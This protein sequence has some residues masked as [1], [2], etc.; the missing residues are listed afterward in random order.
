M[1]AEFPEGGFQRQLFQ[2][3]ANSRL[4][5][6]KYGPSLTSRGEEGYSTF[7]FWHERAPADIEDLLRQDQKRVLRWQGREAVPACPPSD[8][9]ALALQMK[10][11]AG[12]PHAK[13][14][15]PQVA[16]AQRSQKA[17]PPAA[18]KRNPN[19]SREDVRKAVQKADE[20]RRR[21]R[22]L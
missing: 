3:S 12:H 1:L 11:V 22:G 13:P 17:P 4:L 8:V 14:A 10:A 19:A 16:Q 15:E 20:L 5:S 6:C 18:T 21:L 9:Q 7:H 2:S